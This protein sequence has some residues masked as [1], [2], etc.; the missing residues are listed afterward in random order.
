MLPDIGVPRGCTSIYYYLTMDYEVWNSGFDP[1]LRVSS[2]ELIAQTTEALRF[3]GLAAMAGPL[4]E[5]Q[6][7]LS[8]GRSIARCQARSFAAQAEAEPQNVRFIRGHTHDFTT[9]GKD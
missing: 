2:S 6:R 1:W 3:L 7:R 8:R 9:T 5:A 4:E